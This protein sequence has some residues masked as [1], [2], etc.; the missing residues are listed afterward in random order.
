MTRSSRYKGSHER[1]NEMQTM[2]YLPRTQS[3]EVDRYWKEGD[4]VIGRRHH[5]KD[6]TGVIDG[7]FK[8]PVIEHVGRKMCI[9]V[10][11]YMWPV[12]HRRA[13]NWFYSSKPAVYPFAHIIENRTLTFIVIRIQRC[14][15]AY[16]LKRTRAASLIQHIFKI[17]ISNP[18]YELCR[19]RLQ[20]EWQELTRQH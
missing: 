2:P 12:R 9:L 17:S 10:D 4:L 14:W 19:K 15:R 8:W 11:M 13:H 6:C 7:S 3:M 5:M 1:Q 20:R 16:N 18:E